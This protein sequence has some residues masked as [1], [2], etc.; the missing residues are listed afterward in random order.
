MI[1]AKYNTAVKVGATFD[2]VLTWKTGD[3]LAA[4]NLTGYTAK[5]QVRTR[6]GTLVV[7]LS[8]AN[9]RIT[10]GGAAGTISLLLTASETAA[11][12]A[13]KYDFDL[14]L[15]SGTGE[16]YVLLDGTI[17]FLERTTT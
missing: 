15:T 9:G 13:G 16:V 8:T 10:L 11:I 17:Q 12:A 7:E 5:M 14:K 4:V 3:P 1:P 2:P 6:T